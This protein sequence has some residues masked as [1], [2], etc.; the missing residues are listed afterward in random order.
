MMLRNITKAIGVLAIPLLSVL[1]QNI[2]PVDAFR[3]VPNINPQMRGA[4]YQALRRART[5][6]INFSLFDARAAAGFRSHTSSEPS[7]DSIRLDLLD[8]VSVNMLWDHVGPTYDGKATV[9]SGSIEGL[10][11]GEG[12]LVVTGSMMVGHISLVGHF[13]STLTYFFVGISVG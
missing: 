2:R 10:P 5:V 4:P 7:R 13:R 1:A 12:T 3:F 11:F 9:W 6:A 8:D